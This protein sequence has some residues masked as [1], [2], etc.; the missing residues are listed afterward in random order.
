MNF[1]RWLIKQCDRCDNVG[2]LG[3]L[4]YHDRDFP[5]MASWREYKNYLYGRDSA[6]EVFEGF[7]QA[8]DEYWEQEWGEAFCRWQTLKIFQGR[9]KRLVQVIRH[10]VR[11]MMTKEQS[12]DRN[13]RG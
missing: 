5:S 3:V 10:Y 7:E 6:E 11:R 1:R 2:G 4:A 9:Q 13:R 12:F 8:W